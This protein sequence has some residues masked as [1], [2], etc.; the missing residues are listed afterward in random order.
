MLYEISHGLRGE[1]MKICTEEKKGFYFTPR[2]EDIFCQGS[3][4]KNLT[5]TP[6]LKYKYV[7]EM[8]SGYFGKSFVGS[9]FDRAVTCIFDHG[10]LH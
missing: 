6:L 8:K 3:E 10:T 4:E 2:I 7:Y 9:F 1:F 5:D